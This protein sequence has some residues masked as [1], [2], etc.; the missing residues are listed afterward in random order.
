LS[1][2]TNDSVRVQ[3]LIALC[4]EFTYNNPEKAL[5]FF[6]KARELA[7]SSGNFTGLA[8]SYERAGNIYFHQGKKEQSREHYF[9]ALEVNRQAGDYEIDASIF[10]NLGNLFYE[11]GAFDSA[12]YYAGNAAEVFLANNDSIGFAATRY[13][14]IG[15]YKDQGMYSLAMQS[16]IQALG[17]FQRHGVNN[18]EIFTLN[19]LIDLYNIQGN[20]VESL[21]MVEKVL[22]SYRKDNNRKFEA[23]ALR[24]KGDI[25]IATEQY[26]EAREALSQ[27]LD[28]AREGSFLPEQAKTLI[29][30]GLLQ[31]SQKD[32]NSA[33]TSYREALEIC[34]Q[35]N[36][37]F[38][39]S[40]CHLGAGKSLFHLGKMDEALSGLQK[41]AETM[42]RFGDYSYLREIHLYLSQVHEEKGRYRESL[43]EY[44]L[45]SDYRDSLLRAEKSRELGEIT[46]KYENELKE[47][48]IQLLQNEKAL[49]VKN[50]NNLV[51]IGLL[52]IVLAGSS[53]SFLILRVRKNRQLVM[54]SEEVDQMKSR[55]FANISH[56]FRT[57]ISLILSPLYELKRQPLLHVHN[58]TLKLIE[59]NARRL[60][61][62]V[63]QILDLS[64]LEEGKHT[65]RIVHDDLC[66]FLRRVSS[67]F[68][69]LAESGNT[70]FRILIPEEPCYFNFDP[71]K[72]EIIINN[73]LSNAFRHEPPK[74]EVTMEVAFAEKP[75]AVRI[76][77]NN[78]G[79]R[80]P[81]DT[82]TAHL[83]PV[84]FGG[85]IL[86][87][88]RHWT[89]AG[90]GAYRPVRRIGK[91]GKL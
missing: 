55:F 15:I 33:L 70:R 22:Q 56:E 42:K 37:A 79:S 27:S 44:K 60:L 46:A 36:D 13:L 41:A 71:D 52:L 19:N 58:P 84:L 81:P 26:E 75:S 62:L 29:S 1:R 65:T 2:A 63:N 9:R 72:L 86:H 53:I 78:R 50:R 85:R 35:T 67:S 74:G 76:T 40:V 49:V 64:K 45:Y 66:A 18:W 5:Q 23:V 16:G 90:K 14:S 24:Y 31:H 83:R 28:I 12:L 21:E 8:R 73:L 51:I 39:E 88:N 17:I 69:S 25:F 11:T 91:G 59:Q 32:Y 82:I 61:V 38:Y 48:Q 54:K 89:C 4:D 3:T 57:P 68:T 87:R 80:I 77:I 20:Y 43:Q 34:V 7:E 6:E 47:E 30:Q 10:Y